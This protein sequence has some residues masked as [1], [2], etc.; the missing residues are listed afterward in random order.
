[1]TV[2][3]V[4]DLRIERFIIKKQLGSDFRVTTLSSANE[5]VAFAKSHEFDIAL[6]NLMLRD[7]LEGIHLLN[8]LKRINRND[9]LA[10]AT[11]CYV[12]QKRYDA[13]MRSGFHA[14]MI[15][16]LNLDRFR[17]LAESQKI[18]QTLVDVS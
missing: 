9:F 2:L 8:K 11:T 13:V 12:D 14:L 5:A 3:A 18:M 17:Y 1:M 15:K 6:I 10:I 4:D 7:D 16:P